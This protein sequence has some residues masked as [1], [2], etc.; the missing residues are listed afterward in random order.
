LALEV[1]CDRLT[2]ASG[3]KVNFICKYLP[4]KAN[5]IAIV[6]CGPEAY[7][8]EMLKTRSLEALV[9]W[10]GGIIGEQYIPDV[11][12]RKCSKAECAAM[13]NVLKP[14][15]S[16]GG[17]PPRRNSEGSAG[18]RAGG[19]QASGDAEKRR[20]SAASAAGG[21]SAGAAGSDEE[22]DDIYAVAQRPTR[23]RAGQACWALRSGGGGSACRARRRSR[24][25]LAL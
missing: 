2:K 20:K 16:N 24:V 25:A 3:D 1:L 18:K 12:E 6:A 10:D 22:Y 9:G 7:R 13:A 17:P 23:K 19:G 5:V 14:A 21:G 11:C 15:R 8:L 4:K